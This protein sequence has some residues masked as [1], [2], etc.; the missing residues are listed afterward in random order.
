MQSGQTN[1]R[2]GSLSRAY[3]FVKLKIFL[4]LQMTPVLSLKTHFSETE[5]DTQMLKGKRYS[6][7]LVVYRLT[8][9]LML[10]SIVEGYISSMSNLLE[11][12]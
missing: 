8:H 5:Q 4:T 12:P 6:C 10:N 3:F 7:L 11:D 1:Q 2:V 9:F